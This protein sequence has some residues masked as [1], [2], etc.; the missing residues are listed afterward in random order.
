MLSNTLKDAKYLKRIK[1]TTDASSAP[2][3]PRHHS[4]KMQAH[5]DS[6]DDDRL[7]SYY[8]NGRRGVD[9]VTS[10]SGNKCPIT[11]NHENQQGP[12]KKK[13]RITYKKIMPYR[14]K[15]GC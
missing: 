10:Y 4:I 14:L 3:H 8:K 11:R 6:Y 15:V 2:K 1:D 7:L 9:S 5:A 13:E 12:G